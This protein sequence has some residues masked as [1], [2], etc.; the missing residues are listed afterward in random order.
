MLQAAADRLKDGRGEMQEL[1]Y[2]KRAADLLKKKELLNR[3]FPL[4]EKMFSDHSNP[5]FQRR[6]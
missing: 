4:P 3:K 6:E 5:V 1:R 2:L